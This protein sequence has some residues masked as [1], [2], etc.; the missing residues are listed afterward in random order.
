MASANF[1][2]LVQIYGEDVLDRIK[3]CE[4][5]YK[6][7]VNKRAH[8]LG[9]LGMEFKQL[10]LELLE[11]GTKASYE[12][13]LKELSTFLDSN[14]QSK[15]R[16]DWLNWWHHRRHSI[17][18]AFTMLNAPRMNQAEVINA[19]FVNRNEVGVPLITSAEFDVKDS[20]YLAADL[21]QFTWTWTYADAPNAKERSE[22]N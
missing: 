21:E 5:H 17:F 6:K 16:E 8:K 2:G 18:R 4:F 20:L 9:E 13:A 1:N 22:A 7:S 3:G 11:S 12:L 14:G 10:S 15:L 19:G